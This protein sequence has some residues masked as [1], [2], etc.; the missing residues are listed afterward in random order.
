MYLDTSFLKQVYYDIDTK[1][2]VPIKI[3]QMTVNI[4]LTKRPR[5]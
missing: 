5:Q 2:R 1:Y 3:K 4:T